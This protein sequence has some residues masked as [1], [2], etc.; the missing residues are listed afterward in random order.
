MGRAIYQALAHFVLQVV[1]ALGISAALAVLWALA[2]GGAFVHTFGTA[3]FV[4]GGLALLFGAL[5]VGGMS[6]SQGLVETA[7][8]S[9]NPLPG[10]PAFFRTSPGTTA[11]NATAIFFLT[12]LVMLAIGFAI[13]G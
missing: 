12:G 11:V 9:T 10:M 3:C 13:H 5:G 2:H 8:R 7:G 4:V 6:P 1:V